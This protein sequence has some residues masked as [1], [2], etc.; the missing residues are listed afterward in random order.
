MSGICG[1]VYFDGEPVDPAQLEKMAQA[2]AHR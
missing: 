2:M 1:I